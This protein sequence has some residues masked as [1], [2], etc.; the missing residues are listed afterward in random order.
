M[1]E[2]S[3]RT[4]NT[5]VPSWNGALGQPE[6]LVRTGTPKLHVRSTIARRIKSSSN[7]R[8]NIAKS[9][10]SGRQ[11]ISSLES[12]FAPT[13]NVA[14]PKP[15]PKCCL[16]RSCDVAKT[17]VTS[18]EPC[19]GPWLRAERDDGPA[20]SWPW[21]GR[22]AGRR[23]G[24]AERDDGPA[25]SLGRLLQITV[26]HMLPGALLRSCHHVCCDASGQHACLRQ[27]ES[28]MLPIGPAGVP[29]RAKSGPIEAEAKLGQPRGI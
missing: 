10:F 1:S 8:R 6:D 22:R 24:R 16:S 13:L 4:C 19:P 5:S 9:L 17:E 7:F 3:E 12:S 18:R 28:E 11:S 23:A 15:S 27:D 25:G 21:A 26:N 29:I 2:T 14:K 20:G